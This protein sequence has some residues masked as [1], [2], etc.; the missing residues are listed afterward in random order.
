ML[1]VV[2][3]E[4]IFFDEGDENDSIFT[5]KYGKLNFQT[6]ETLLLNGGRSSISAKSRTKRFTSDVFGIASDIRLYQQPFC[7]CS[8]VLKIGDMKTLA[9]F[10]QDTSKKNMKKGEVW[11]L[12]YQNAPLKFYCKEHSLVNGLPNVWLFTENRYVR[13]KLG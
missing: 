7:G 9:T 10:D 5:K 2:L 11:F 4:P 12:S 6:A 13:C 8:G 3:P 1:I